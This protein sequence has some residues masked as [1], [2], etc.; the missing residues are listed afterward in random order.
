MRLAAALVVL[1]A[2]G[3]A[4]AASRPSSADWRPRGAALRGDIT[5]DGRPETALIEY[6]GRPSC[7]FRLVV[8]SL[9]GRVRPEICDGKPG[10]VWSGAD[11]H[12]AVLADLD[13]RPGL[14][15]VVQLGHGAHTEFADLWAVRDGR[16]RRFDGHEPHMSYGGS[17]GTG[18]HFVDCS[19]KPGVILMSTQV[20]R[21]PARIVRTWYRTHGLSLRRVGTRS[22]RWPREKPVPFREFGYPQ[23]FPTCAEARAP[24]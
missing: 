24:R 18:A 13:S 5:G 20:H 21:S 15:I 10:E 22:V 6:R 4:F 14:E 16:L 17:V 1:V 19:R 7:D 2:A 8:G 3:S 12:V 11:P 9:V 23:P